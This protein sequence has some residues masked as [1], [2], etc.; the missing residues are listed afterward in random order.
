M[1]SD[2]DDREWLCASSGYRHE[3]HHAIPVGVKESHA[4]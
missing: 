1:H 3:S 4:L 2:T